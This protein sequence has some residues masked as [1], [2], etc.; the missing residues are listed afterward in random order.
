VRIARSSSPKTIGLARLGGGRLIDQLT[1]LQGE[2][3]DGWV[4]NIAAAMEEHLLSPVAQHRRLRPLLFHLLDNLSDR[5]SSAQA[6]R[7]V[8]VE[9]KYF[10]KFFQRE[11]GFKFAWWNREIRIRLAVRLLQEKGR[12]IESVAVAVGYIDLTTF[13]RAFKKCNGICP[14]AY[15]RSHNATPK[16]SR[17]TGCAVVMTKNAE[18]RTTN[19][20]CSDRDDVDAESTE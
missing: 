19:A 4:D 14:L 6:A 18:K 13:A 15:R 5:L 20:D 12:N 16:P 10:S 17:S 2:S 7:I 8:S 9:R 3:P 11:T 1:D